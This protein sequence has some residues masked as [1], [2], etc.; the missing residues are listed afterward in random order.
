[1]LKNLEKNVNSLFKKLGKEIKK[2]KLKKFIDKGKRFYYDFLDEK[3][4]KVKIKEEK[5]VLRELRT[6]VEIYR[7]FGKKFKEKERF[8][9]KLLSFGKY[10]NLDFI[11][12]K[13]ERGIFGGEME[14]DFR[15]KK[16]FLKKIDP[17]KFS[18]IIFLYQRIK[19][20]FKLYLHGGWW[21]E[22]D[23]EY[24]KKNFLE[25][26]LK[27]KLNKNLLF[28]RDINLA[29][30]IM[31]KN[32][33]FLDQKAKYLCHGDLYPNN[34]ILN[35]KKNL[36]I[37]D[38]S[39]A[40]FNNLAFDV[41]FIYL[42]ANSLPVWQEKFLKSYLKMINEREEFKELFRIDLISL[43]NRFASQCYQLKLKEK[44]QR[45]TFLIFKNYLTF[46]KKA[47]NQKI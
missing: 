42:M 41:A 19:P 12:E 17:K 2:E 47:I 33:N 45:K 46:F 38:W 9:P 26:F 5:K 8:F 24:H 29:T 22:R 37:L 4:I 30:K 43:A 15:I 16:S 1:M 10:K 40:T 39:M 34:L 13:K 44:F 11:V 35:E 23:F 36:I 32:K 18:E 25:K 31:E 20:K 7:T 27:S 3:F 21:F 14:K 6:E 28:Q